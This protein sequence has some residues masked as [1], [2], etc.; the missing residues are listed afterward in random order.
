VSVLSGVRGMRLST[1]LGLAMAGILVLAALAEATVYLRTR[2]ETLEEANASYQALAKAIEVAQTQMGEKGWKDER[3]LGDYLKALE[4]RGLRDIKV[5]DEKGQPFPV[6]FPQMP[7][8]RKKQT[9]KEIFISGVVGEGPTNRT[10]EIPVVVDGKLQGYIELRYTLENIREQLADNFRRRLF[11]LLGVFALGL[12]VILVIVRNAT[13]PVARLA[14]GASRVADG[15]LDV[16]VAVDRADEIGQLAAAF[17]NMTGRLRERHLLEARLAAAEKRAEI[18]Q[19]ASGLAHE[20]KNPLNALSLGLDV[21]RRRHRPADGDAGDYATRIEALRK[22]INR[23]AELIN[24][25]LA[26]GRPLEVS[27]RPSDLGGIVTATLADLAETAERARVAVRSEVAPALPPLDLDASLVKSALWNL[28][29]NAV[30]AMERT[31][32]DLCV[33]VAPA[34][35]AEKG[36]PSRVVV[37]VEDTGPGFEPADLSRLFEPYYSK[38]EGGVGLGL[39]MVKRI[40]EEHGGRVTAE[41]RTDGSPGARFRLFFPLATAA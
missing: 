7:G 36:G 33:S 29:Q 13:Q 30:Q 11:A 23:L 4:S 2:N 3:V 17:N 18:G 12:A 8:R 35:P 37:T 9:A 5:T 41:N 40:V 26:F 16:T 39:A 32:G 21:L 22:E 34:A 27:L 24:N 25:F 14:E 28:V 19:L 15:K 31:G 10:L 6:P 20:I 38:K 1:R